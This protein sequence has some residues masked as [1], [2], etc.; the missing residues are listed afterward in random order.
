M[1][2]VSYYN[3]I[4]ICHIIILKLFLAGVGYVLIFRYTII[5]NST[6]PPMI[7]S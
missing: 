4:V 1:L 3:I 2:V 6:F 7:L 5:V